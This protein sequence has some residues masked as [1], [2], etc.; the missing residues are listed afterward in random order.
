MSLFNIQNSVQEV[1]EAIQ[2]ILGVDVTIIDSSMYRVAATGRYR[3]SVGA[4]LPSSCSFEVVAETKLPQIIEKPNISEECLGCSQKGNCSEM[5]TLG[6]PILNDG[7][8]EGVIGL[9]A[10][11]E[12]QKEKIHRQKDKLVVF[13]S[14]LSDLISGNINYNNTIK[15]ITVQNEETKMIIDRLDKGIIVVDEYEN[16]KSVNRNAREYL[17]L[18]I[19]GIVGKNIGEIFP[20][21]NSREKDKFRIE[22]KINIRGESK[23]F[24]IKHIPVLVDDKKMSSIIEVQKTFD[25]VK[26]AYKL[27]EGERQILF[28]DILGS[29][30][31]LE[32]VKNI[33][34]GVADSDSTV[35]L[36]GESGTGKELFARAIHFESYRKKAPFIAINCASIPDNLIE[37]ELFGYEGG[38]FSGAK[39]EGKMGKFELA[40][41]GTL[42]LD[43][44]GDLPLHIQPKLLR[45][46]QE[47][48]FMRVGGKEKI[49]INFRLLSATNRDIEEMVEN[50][51]FREDL[52]YRLNVIPIEIPPLRDRKDDIG[53]LS[54]YLLEKNCVK[55]GKEKK[56]FSDE[57]KANILKYS[58][59]GNIREME[60]TIEYLVNLVEGKEIKTE[61]L[62][63]NIAKNLLQKQVKDDEFELTLSEKIDQYEKMILERYL[64]EFGNSTCNKKLISE[65]L[66]INLS[67]LYRKLSKH[68]LQ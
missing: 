30:K 12:N 28:K 13:L 45:A 4:R 32:E 52:Y 57:L 16:I 61:D 49:N 15:K 63:H 60:N 6:Y 8:L 5:A 59:P 1:A 11:D 40:N 55:L 44:I 51:E 26:D 39:K 62:P 23:S 19:E 38:A 25:L 10:F 42:F 36:R 67:T 9:I 20:N 65:K 29:S 43:E 21:L 64:F 58:W 33:A 2:A 35:F 34:R 56:R 37:S 7:R 50:G 66:N 41:K 27:I 17:K 24:I 46:L 48:S 68:N 54:E 31:K 18:N 22:K 3:E 14:K 53:L 47:K